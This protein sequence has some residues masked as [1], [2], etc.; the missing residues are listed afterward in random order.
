MGRHDEIARFTET[1]APP[2]V[3]W[4]LTPGRNSPEEYKGREFIYDSENNARQDAKSIRGT[5]TMVEY[6]GDKKI[7][8]N[9]EQSKEET[10]VN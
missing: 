6:V 7:I 10:K 4:K 5:V 2:N 1:S 8:H 3:M 9:N